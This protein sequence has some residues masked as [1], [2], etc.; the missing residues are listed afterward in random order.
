MSRPCLFVELWADEC[1][2]T[3][4]FTDTITAISTDSLKDAWKIT[5][6]ST[7]RGYCSSPS[8]EWLLV[9][10][11]LEVVIRAHLLHQPV[12]CAKEG[13]E[14]TNNLERLGADPRSLGLGVFRVAGL[15]GVVHAGLG[16]LW[17]VGYLVVNTTVELSHHHGVMLLLLLV[18]CAG[19]G[20]LGRSKLRRQI[21][22][23][24]WVLGVRSQL[25]HLPS[26]SFGWRDDT[27]RYVPQTGRVVAEVDAEGSIDVIHDFPCHQEAEFYRFHVEVKVPPAQ[28][29]LGLCRCFWWRLDF[30]TR[31]V[32]ILVKGLW[33]VLRPSVWTKRAIWR[34][35]VFSGD[36]LQA[37][38]YLLDLQSGSNNICLRFLWLPRQAQWFGCLLNLGR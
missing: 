15:P 28:D 12:I 2:Q 3:R 7:N 30:R 37:F 19:A 34:H 22:V 18:R 27:D 26:Y 13:D 38:V 4:I 8:A 33:E 24:D 10:L 21:R 31:T 1:R 14:D 32:L 36:D 5:V 6:W 16:L 9:R 35:L 29:L 17:P 20:G 25:K 11:R 23:Q